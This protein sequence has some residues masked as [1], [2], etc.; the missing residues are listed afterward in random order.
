MQDQSNIILYVIKRENRKV[1]FNALSLLFL[2]LTKLG[3]ITKGILIS[4]EMEVDR[5]MLKGKMST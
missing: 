1:Q 3:R 5:E 4:C 2:F